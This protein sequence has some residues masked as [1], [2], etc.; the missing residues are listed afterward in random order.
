MIVFEKKH[1]FGRFF[2]K[3]VSIIDFFFVILPAEME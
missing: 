1:V 3:K 2:C